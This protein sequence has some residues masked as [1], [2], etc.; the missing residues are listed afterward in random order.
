[1]LH[2]VRNRGSVP[3]DMFALKKLVLF[4]VSGGAMPFH[5]IHKNVGQICNTYLSDGSSQA[6]L[7]KHC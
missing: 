4:C 5:D 1:M 6:E 3:R 7:N 2:G